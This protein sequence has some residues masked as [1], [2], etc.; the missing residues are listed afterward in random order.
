MRCDPPSIGLR[1]VRWIT[2]FIAL[3]LLLLFLLSSFRIATFRTTSYFIPAS[4]PFLAPRKWT[5][6]YDTN[7]GRKI[8][9]GNWFIRLFGTHS[10]VTLFGRWSTAHSTNQ[11]YWR[12]FSGSSSSGYNE[13]I[14]TA[15]AAAAATEGRE[16]SLQRKNESER[17]CMKGM[18]GQW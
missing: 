9:F 2:A 13:R 17:R 3:L 10:V 16:F 6:T 4:F 7:L 8:G 11:Y 5:S 12:H 1:V 18:N 14:T 15:T